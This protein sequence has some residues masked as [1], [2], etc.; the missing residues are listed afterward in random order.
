MYQLESISYSGNNG[1]N[2]EKNCQQLQRLTA[3]YIPTISYQN[4]LHTSTLQLFTLRKGHRKKGGVK[5]GEGGKVG[6]SFHLD[7]CHILGFKKEGKDDTGLQQFSRTELIISAFSWELT[8]L[9]SR[10]I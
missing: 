7:S 10:E 2:V 8:K 1:I 4:I 6:G 9:Q 3:T 5:K